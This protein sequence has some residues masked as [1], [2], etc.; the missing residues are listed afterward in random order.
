MS[1][2]IVHQ[3][4]TVLEVDDAS[5]LAEIEQLIDLEDFILARLSDR[6]VAVDPARTGELAERLKERGRLA[7]IRRAR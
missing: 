2:P 6:S 1:Q 4:L 5:V 3:E 7:L